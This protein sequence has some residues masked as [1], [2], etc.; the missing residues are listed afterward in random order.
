MNHNKALL[1]SLQ[2]F[3][4]GALDSLEISNALVENKFFHYVV[5]SNKN[6][7]KDEFKD[8]EFRKVFLIETFESNIKSFLINTFLKFNFLRLI[9]II[10]KTKP[11]NI[12]FTHR[13]PWQIFILLLKPFLN[14]KIIYSC[15][16]NPFDPKDPENKVNLFIDKLLAKKSDI[17]VVYS[18]FIK[19]D[20]S[21]FIKKEIIVIPLG[22]YNYF[23][24]F[25]KTNFN[26]EKLVIGFWGRI[27]EY[28]GLNILLKAFE[29]L[30]K[31]GLN[32]DLYI[33]GQGKISEEEKVLIEK[34]KVHFV[35][36]WLS[37]E[38]VI[39]YMEKI[40]LVVLPYVKATQSAIISFCL[41][42]NMPFIASNAGG[43][44]EFVE[45][46]KT[47]FVFENGDYIDLAEK[48]KIIY[49]NKEPLKTF[50]ENIKIFKTNFEWKNTI[51][52]LLDHLE[53]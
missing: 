24:Y 7:L 32:I 47:V 50:S 28:K 14:F 45:D 46:R 40:D 49:Q 18:N 10:L 41:A 19:E 37:Y 3:G 6:E 31:E 30:K 29:V 26:S 27:L 9:K 21:R 52:K 53:R 13:H 25:Q 11:K 39:N 20:L 33:L 2:K 43:L 36:K 35:N 22:P 15:H 8:N 16:D 38:E 44:K 4:A 5:I 48:I 34:L 1:I 51:K 12:F 42:I 23:S 17:I